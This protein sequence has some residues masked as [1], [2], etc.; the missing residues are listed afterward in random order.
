MNTKVVITGIG[1]ISPFGVGNDV[2][3]KNLIQGKSGLREI[4]RFDTTLLKSRMAGEVLD[5]R[6]EDL[7]RIQDCIE[8]PEFLS[9]L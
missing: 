4:T 3:W 5:F 7:L 9:L 2:F 8:Y 1:I 6:I